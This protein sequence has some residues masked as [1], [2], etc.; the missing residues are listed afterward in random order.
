ME[1]GKMGKT[2][3]FKAVFNQGGVLEAVIEPLH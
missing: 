2:Y 3:R 1:K